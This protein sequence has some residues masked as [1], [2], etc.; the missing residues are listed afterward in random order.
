MAQLEDGAAGQAT[1]LGGAR[2]MVPVGG[3]AAVAVTAL[4]LH[5]EGVEQLPRL[6]EP[7]LAAAM[8]MEIL[9]DME[10]LAWMLEEDP[11]AG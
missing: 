11:D 9:D 8:E 3:A 10:F 2:W 5:G 6:A 1:W 7:E 4:L